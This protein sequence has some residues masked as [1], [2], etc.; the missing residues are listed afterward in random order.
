MTMQRPFK[1]SLCFA[2]GSFGVICIAIA[3]LTQANPAWAATI[4][5]IV[6]LA[7]S[8]APLAAIYGG[9]QTRAFWVGFAIFGWTHIILEH[10]PFGDIEL[11]SRFVV[12]EVAHRAGLMPK[13]PMIAA[14]GVVLPPP[15]ATPPLTTLDVFSFKRIWLSISAG[16]F[17]T[18]G[19]IVASVLAS[20]RQEDK[21]GGD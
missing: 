7:V 11:P 3:A 2:G 15:T 8:I 12:D 20:R 4:T 13:P 17:A 5:G 16:L 6:L 10:G 9:K 19:G 14:R 18:V 21:C 1:F